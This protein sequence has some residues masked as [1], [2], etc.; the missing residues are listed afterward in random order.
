M[1]ADVKGALLNAG[2][3]EEELVESPKEFGQH[4]NDA[5]LMIWLCDIRKVAR[6]GKNDY[7]RKLVSDG[8]RGGMAALT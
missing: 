6:S 7:A 5:R 3:D 8:L 2:C 1:L 4:G